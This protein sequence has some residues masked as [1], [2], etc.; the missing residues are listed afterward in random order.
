M[1]DSRMPLR[2]G[3]L[4]CLAALLLLAAAPAAATLQP[5]G[6]ERPL[7]SADDCE[8]AEP[9]LAAL[10]GGGFVGLFTNGALLQVR[11]LDA[12]GVPSGPPTVVA[13]GQ[14]VDPE[15]VALPD[16]GYAVV[17]FDKVRRAISARRADAAGQ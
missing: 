12:S 6:D 2:H 17:W 5:A 8:Q 1:G 4:G 14:I 10:T 7:D 16:G 9:A 11:R 3:P 13:T 15:V